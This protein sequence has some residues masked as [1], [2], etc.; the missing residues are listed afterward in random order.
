MEAP[1]FEHLHYQLLCHPHCAIKKPLPA[2]PSLLVPLFVDLVRDD[3][4][5]S[6]GMLGGTSSLGLAVGPPGFSHSLP[7]EVCQLC[8]L[9]PG[10]DEVPFHRMVPVASALPRR[11]DRG[12]ACGG[13]W[14]C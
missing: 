9:P 13:L 2:S 3:C 6:V 4:V 12:R 7:S 14:G 5:T 8:A 1:L 10:C 11:E